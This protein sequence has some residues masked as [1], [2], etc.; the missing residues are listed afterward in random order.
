MRKIL[1]IL[2]LHFSPIAYSQ[3][4]WEWVNPRPT[5]SHF[6]SSHFINDQTG[7][8]STVDATVLKTTNGGTN[9]TT[10]YTGYYRNFT[11]IYFLSKDTGFITTS[12]NSLPPPAQNF[13]LRTTNGGNNWNQLYAFNNSHLS[14]INFINNNTGFII[15]G[16]YH[17]GGYIFKTTNAGLN[18]DLYPMLPT[19]IL[20]S[21]CFT[22]INTGYIGGP[23][24]EILKTTNTGNNW[25]RSDSGV[26]QFPSF[27]SIH[28]TTSSTG[29]A[30]AQSGTLYKTTNSGDY[31]HLY[32]TGIPYHLI[33]IKFHNPNTGY[34]L[35]N[36]SNGKIFKTSN[37]GLVWDSI[38][39]LP[40][41]VKLSKVSILDS[42]SAFVFG[43]F[44]T[45]IKTTNKG[46]DWIS[47]T[48][49][50][51][52]FNLNKIYFIDSLTG[53]IVG[54]SGTIL[55]SI[56]KGE[57]WYTL[58]S[59]TI[60]NLYDIKA[61]ND[62][63]YCVGSKGTILKSTN[64]G[65]SWVIIDYANKDNLSSIEFV[66]NSIFVTDFHPKQIGFYG[67]HIY[68]SSN[69]GLNWHL[70]AYPNVIK[71][72]SI[73]FI[74]SNTGFAI[75]GSTPYAGCLKTTNG[76]NNWTRTNYSGMHN[77]IVKISKNSFLVG[78][79]YSSFKTSNS[80]DNWNS[81]SLPSEVAGMTS[82]YSVDD[83]I[84]FA[85][86][87]QGDMGHII[88]S[89]NAG[90]NWEKIYTPTFQSVSKLN[91]LVFINRNTGFAVGTAG[92]ILKTTDGGNTIGIVNFNNSTPIKFSLHQNYPNP[93]NPS[94]K[95]KFELPKS[96][97]ASLKVYDTTGR[98]ITTLVNSRL[99]SGSYSYDFNG[100]G[101][102][103]GMYFYRL[104]TDAY[105]ETKKM[106]L[107]K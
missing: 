50:I 16:R 30:V 91:S 104:E 106:I 32:S 48:S 27:A 8:A 67:S 80:G 3:S 14:Q 82:L 9:W 87:E 55:K 44:G 107:I 63:L 47:N 41:N 72:T 93:F 89:T 26:A 2:L 15:G 105:S 65:F 99:S 13:L 12:D 98:L 62:S 64:G 95:I 56:D 92:A 35:T 57:T 88:K 36:S 6:T 103:S 43:N 29:Y 76:G 31:W 96:S 40:A 83:S 61:N 81:F 24:G 54:D 28:F 1:L 51:S 37:A 17:S 53:Y 79:V 21:I 5:G 38:P 49:S 84:V 45:L 59:N 42:S 22:D 85:T 23:D 66:N 101:L 19:N 25:F 46:L 71:L 70:L 69:G 74:N 4:N 7:F 60:E 78:G 100:A 10:I 34:I 86:V 33:D 18:W 73:I 68:K 52:G 58:Q 20:N 90:A 94:T 39:L 75:G 11:S 102:S 77:G 97:F